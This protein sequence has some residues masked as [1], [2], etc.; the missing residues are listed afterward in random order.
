MIGVA[1][2]AAGGT[3]RIR[4]LAEESTFRAV[5]AIRCRSAMS[6]A[7]DCVRGLRNIAR[8]RSSANTDLDLSPSLPARETDAFRRSSVRSPR[9]CVTSEPSDPFDLQ[10]FVDAQN[11]VYE[12]VCAELRNGQKRGHWMWVVFPQFRGKPDSLVIAGCGALKFAAATLVGVQVIASNTRSEQIARGVWLEWFTVGYNSLEGL[13]ALVAGFLAGSIALVG[14]G[15]DSVIEVTSGGALLWRLRADAEES[16]R[17]KMET[18]ALRIV[19]TCFLGL[20]VY[21]GYEGITSLANKKIP[22]HSLAGIILAIV[23]LMVMPL[24]ARAKRRVAARLESAALTADAIQTE[25]CMYLSAILLCGLLLNALLGWWWA[26]PMAGLLMVPIIAK[27]GYDALR[28][29]T[30]CAKCS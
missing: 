18:A 17:E 29:K 25:F 24:L 3:G 12:G 21:V 26:D 27:E 13:I 5:A 2:I 7:A 30:C 20:A 8:Q 11:A 19:G 28:G 14:F 10:R 16:Q 23:S 4:S 15:L 9:H 6:G 22:E 1:R